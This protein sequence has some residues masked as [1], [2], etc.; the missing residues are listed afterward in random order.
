MA[1]TRV[2]ISPLTSLQAAVD[3]WLWRQGIREP[4]IRSLLWREFALAGLT[5]AAGAVLA[6]FS[7]WLLWFGVGLGVMSWIFWSW[8]RFFSRM[9][10]GI[11]QGAL[12]GA[13]LRWLARLLVLA[14]ALYGAL[15]VGASALAL[16][17]GVACGV[18]AALASY[19]AGAGKDK[20]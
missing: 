16:A 5:L 12:M 20:L 6:A 10:G 17:A 3:A 13:L 14:L 19:A 18:G 2:K 8:A 9:A 15:N 1:M 7:A 4:L 11:Q